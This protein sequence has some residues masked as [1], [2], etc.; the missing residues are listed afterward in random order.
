MAEIIALLITIAF[1]VWFFAGYLGSGG[2]FPKPLTPEEEEMYLN[3][4]YEGDKKAREILIER[5]LRLV[6]HVAKKY[7]SL[8]K[9]NEDLIS[10]GT[11]GLIKGVSSYNGS[12]GTKLA[13]YVARC[14]D[15]EI[16]MS[17]RSG[18]KLQNEVS[19]NDVIGTDKEG[20]SITLMD[21]IEDDDKLIEEKVG[22]KMQISYLY[23]KM[24]EVLEPREIE[25]LTK[26]Y[27][28]DNKPAKTQYDIASELGISRSY[29]S[30]IEKKALEKLRDNM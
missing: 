25:I 4:M 5:N 8:G 22:I 27:G 6:A 23:K 26:R 18:K 21:I 17:I 13:T 2:T 1:N 12:R 10:I 29:V 7:S 30:R 28:L 24:K 11:I 16:L 20:N 19:I 14:I 9:D 15:N 3:R